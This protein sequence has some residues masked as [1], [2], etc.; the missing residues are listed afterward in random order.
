MGQLQ[1]ESVKRTESYDS[2]RCG[3]PSARPRCEGSINFAHKLVPLHPPISKFCIELCRGM[4][5]HNICFFS[6][7]LHCA[8]YPI[9]NGHD[10]V[11]KFF[12]TLAI[13]HCP[14]AGTTLNLAS[15]VHGSMVFSNPSNVPPC[16]GSIMG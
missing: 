7:G 2:L 8:L 5:G 10:H 9:P 4:F 13:A 16:A 6:A 1:R 3:C 11:V 15:A 12:Q 14:R